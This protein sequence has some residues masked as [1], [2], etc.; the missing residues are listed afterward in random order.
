[1]N[2]DIRSERIVSDVTNQGNTD[3]TGPSS[4]GRKTTLT[5]GEIK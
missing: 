4:G 5:P 3:V 2:N 1:M